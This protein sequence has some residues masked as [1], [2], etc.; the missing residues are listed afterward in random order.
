[1]DTSKLEELAKPLVE[2][3]EKDCHPYTSVVIS[4]SGI[5]VVEI[6]QSIPRT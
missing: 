6:T 4:G 2:Y 3:L 1:M 5:A